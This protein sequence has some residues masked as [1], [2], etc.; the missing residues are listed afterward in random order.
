MNEGGVSEPAT[1][2]DDIV[3]TVTEV[4]WCGVEWKVRGRNMSLNLNFVMG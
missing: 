3:A 1:V 2:E 4:C